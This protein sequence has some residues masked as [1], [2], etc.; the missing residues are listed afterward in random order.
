LVR[1]D[2]GVVLPSAAQLS[3]LWVTSGANGALNPSDN[4]LRYDPF[5]MQNA[6][7]L[8][9]QMHSASGA[10][11]LPGAILAG[12]DQHI[13]VAYDASLT[14]GL[15]HHAVT[16]IADVDLVN[17]SGSPQNSTA[18]LNVYASDM[19]SLIGVPLTSLTS[20]NIHFI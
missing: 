8:A 17:T 2:G 3:A 20:D 5:P 1:L 15:T 4:V 10:I 18:S 6:Q 14:I 12:Q 9:A 11:L 13:L 7:Q 16:H 19:V